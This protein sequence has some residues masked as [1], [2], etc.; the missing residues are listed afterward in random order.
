MKNINLVNAFDSVSK[1]SKKFQMVRKISNVEFH[2]FYERV[3]SIA[4]LL[5]VNEIMPSICGTQRNQKNVS[6]KDIKTYLI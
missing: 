5:N 4:V 3:K 2:E 1:V 6:F